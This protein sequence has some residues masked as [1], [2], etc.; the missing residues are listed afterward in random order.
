MPP[1]TRTLPLGSRV[2]VCAW[3]ATLMLGAVLSHVPAVTL[4]SCD[5]VTLTLGEPLTPPATST[6][7]LVLAFDPVLSWV[8]VCDQRPGVVPARLPVADQVFVAGSKRSAVARPVV[9]VPLV[10]P[11]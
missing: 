10:R 5:V 9:P 2:S 1:A 3:R 7:P 4:Y 11:P 6:R 8:A